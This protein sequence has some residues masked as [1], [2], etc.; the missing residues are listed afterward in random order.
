[1]QSARPAPP[2]YLV[3]ALAFAVSVVIVIDR[4]GVAPWLQPVTEMLYRWG[5][6]LAAFGL[7]LGVL[8]VA[9]THLRRVFLGESNW[10]YSIA[11]IAA[12]VVVLASG[13]FSPRGAESALTEWLF[14]SIIAPGQAT[15]FALLAF[16]M[17]A[18]AYRYLRVGRNGGGWMLASALLLLTAQAPVSGVWMPPALAQFAA[19][20]LDVPGMATLRGALMGSS[21]AL[22]L[23]AVRFM[24]MTK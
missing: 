12:L 15:L 17:V 4:M 9:W 5:I 3:I 16:F 2:N 7:L 18:A 1:M 23:A 10:P 19:W 8:N 21:I 6:V 22:A 24:F 14:D 20:M 13:L 11:L